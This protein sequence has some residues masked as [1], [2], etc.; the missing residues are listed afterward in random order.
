[1][2]TIVYKDGV[3]A[4]DSR[5][6]AGDL[7]TN[8]DANKK[9]IHNGVIFFMSGCTSDYDKYLDLYFGK[10][11]VYKNIEVSA[12]VFDSGKLYVSS[13]CEDVGLWKTHIEAD[14]VYAIGSG[15][16]FAYTAM[17][18]GLSAKDAV[19]MAIKRDSKSGGKVRTYKL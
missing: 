12:L 13:V 3:V 10:T 8:N 9:H 17:D 16:T 4:Y 18:C 7:I 1:M 11:D 5:E 15:N 19:K 2:T 6:T 14:K